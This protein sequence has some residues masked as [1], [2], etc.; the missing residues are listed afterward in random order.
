VRAGRVWCWGVLNT[1]LVGCA[2]SP[3][4]FL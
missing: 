3:G 1:Q 4:G 2:V